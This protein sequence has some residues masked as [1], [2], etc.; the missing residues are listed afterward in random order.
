VADD[1]FPG[2]FEWDEEKSDQCRSARGFDFFFA[3][4]VFQSD[5]Y[6]EWEDRRRDYGEPRFIS[7]GEIAGEIWAVVWTPRGD[8]RRIISAR[9]ASRQERKRLDD[10]STDF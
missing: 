3:R 4:K 1:Q 6:A 8:V 7:I 2:G 9:R 10:N 5:A